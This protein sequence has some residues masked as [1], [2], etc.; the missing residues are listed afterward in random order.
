MRFLRNKKWFLL[1]HNP[2]NI[3]SCQNFNDQNV[4]A[5]MSMTKDR[6]QKF[7]LVA[8][9]NLLL[10]LRDKIFKSQKIL[11]ALIYG[12]SIFEF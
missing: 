2:K 5:K 11:R 7:Q 8:M 4:I 1:P 3:L 10:K 9:S 12:I 6:Q